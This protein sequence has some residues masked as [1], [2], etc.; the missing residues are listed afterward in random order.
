MSVHVTLSGALP[1]DPEVVPASDVEHFAPR[2]V[3]SAE[4]GYVAIPR[5]E[6]VSFFQQQAIT[7]GVGFSVGLVVGAFFKR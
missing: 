4:R 7:F 3:Y 5:G 1:G 6:V 2:S